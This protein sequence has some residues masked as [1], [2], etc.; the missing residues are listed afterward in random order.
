MTDE[1]L[2]STEST[3]N[4]LPKET[5]EEE[6][7]MI[8]DEIGAS[9]LPEELH[10]VRGRDGAVLFVSMDSEGRHIQY[11]TGLKLPQNYKKALDHPEADQWIAGMADERLGLLKKDVFVYVD[12]LPPGKKAIKSRWVYAYKRNE[13][14][15]IIRWK[16]RLVAKGYEQVP[17][18]DFWTT[19]A[20]TAR[21]ETIRLIIAIAAKYELYLRSIDFTR[22]FC[23]PKLEEEIYM[24]LPNG[25]LVKLLKAL[26]G[27]KQAA[28]EWYKMIREMMK[29]FGYESLHSDNCVFKHKTKPWRFLVVY[30]DDI[31][32]CAK[33]KE[34]TQEMIKELKT[35]GECTDQGQLKWF[36]NM[37]ISYGDNGTIKIDQ[38]KYI[39]KICKKFDHMNPKIE[40]LPHA[41]SKYPSEWKLAGTEAAKK[42]MLKMYPLF[43][44]LI[45]SVMYVARMTR[46]EILWITIALARQ[47][48][49]Y[50]YQ[51]V[52]AAKRILRYLKGTASKGIIY[53]GKSKAEWHNEYLN[54]DDLAIFYDSDW[55]NEKRTRR[56]VTGMISCIANGAVTWCSRR[57]N[58][59]T[60]STVEAEYVAMSEAT[61]EIGYL[62]QFLEELGLDQKAVPTPMYGDSRGAIMLARNNMFHRRTKHIEIAY[63]YTRSR[64]EKG[65]IRLYYIRSEDN[66][67]DI[68]TKPV[69]VTTF[70]SIVQLIGIN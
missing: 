8:Y 59:V 5:E 42:E 66:I 68:L 22:A 28:A 19:F 51:H 12:A 10:Y 64:L 61:C 53:G 57:Q 33:T 46:L 48:Q 39:E 35:I 36:L 23:I 30:V 11:M 52:K 65:D 55:A 26:Y 3:D 38:Q 4:E 18:I 50:T 6:E 62:R 17:G 31:I 25:K 63:H 54:K 27:L 43:K 69:K 20:P 45:A 34:E 60:K 15:R 44:S 40:T 56:S 16:C 37:Q 24:W 1:P 29:Q 13:H 49:D 32:L 9:E 7:E 2:P 14:G 41:P 70:N 47:S 67:S 21:M 58:H